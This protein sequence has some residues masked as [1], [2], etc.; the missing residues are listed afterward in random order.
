MAGDLSHE[1]ERGTS[2]RI[3]SYQ[4]L[5]L[6]RHRRLRPSGRDGALREGWVQLLEIARVL[7]RLDHVGSVIANMVTASCERLR[8]F[9]YSIVSLTSTYHRRPNG[10]TSE[11]RST[12][13]LSLRGSTS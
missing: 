5:W 7:V 3:E 12:P 6:R 11:I 8:C 13:R 2:R 4:Q 1:R 9:A 10:S